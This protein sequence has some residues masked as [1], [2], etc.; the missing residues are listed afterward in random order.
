MGRLCGCSDAAS[1]GRRRRVVCV[2]N[3][4][5][6][7]WFG[8]EALV[9]EREGTSSEAGVRSRCLWPQEHSQRE[10]VVSRSVTS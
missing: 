1:G 7:R 3:A 9:E 6:G 2:R 10:K 5:C 8:Q 4:L